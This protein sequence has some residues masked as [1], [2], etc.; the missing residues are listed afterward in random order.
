MLSDSIQNEDK[1]KD[2]YMDEILEESEDNI[3]LI[4]SKHL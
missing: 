1:Y 3:V 2:E 4:D